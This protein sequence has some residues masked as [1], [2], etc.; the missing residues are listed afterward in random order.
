MMERNTLDAVSP[1]LREL[2]TECHGFDQPQ[3]HNSAQGKQQTLRLGFTVARAHSPNRWRGV[4]SC[5]LRVQICQSLV[6]HPT[7]AVEAGLIRLPFN[8]KPTHRKLLLPATAARIQ[9]AASAQQVVKKGIQK[10]RSFRLSLYIDHDHCNI[11]SPNKKQPGWR[12]GS[13]VPGVT[14]EPGDTCHSKKREGEAAHAVHECRRAKPPGF[15]DAKS[16]RVKEEGFGLH[17]AADGEALL[18]NGQQQPPRI[19]EWERGDENA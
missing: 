6:I 14:A 11:K 12:G 19:Q 4:H 17:A 16:A 18:G 5:H 8:S 15:G 10:Q 2:L 7:E 1:P 3:L 9:A 13:R